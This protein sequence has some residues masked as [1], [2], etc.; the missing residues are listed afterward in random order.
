MTTRLAPASITLAL[1]LLLSSAGA[2]AEMPPPKQRLA[3]WV[4]EHQ[5]ELRRINRSI[6]NHAEV[7]LLEVESSRELQAFL[8]ANG[9]EVEAGVAGMPTA[10]VASYGSG[11][12]VI[13]VLAEYD[14]LP[15]LS[16]TEEPTRSPRPEASAG[17]GCGHSLFGT[18]SAAAAVA[19]RHLMERDGLE[20]TV[21]LYGTPAE[22]TLIGKVYM[23]NAGL[24]DDADA[25]L[26]W[27]PN[28]QTQASYGS[29]KALVS[30]KFR[31]RGLPTGAF[32]VATY[33]YGA[34]AHSWQVV[35][36][37]AHPI[38]E[39]GMLVAAKVMAMSALDLLASP[40]E[41]AAARED[42]AKRT[43]GTTFSSLVPEV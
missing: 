37:S 39:K 36:C 42:F 35:A 16:Q 24:F 30:A 7:G 27:H 29:S 1:A 31:F 15:G 40:E 33:T 4:D 12:P 13:A 21:R 2:S 14:A 28:D 20:G 6:W 26:S 18:A 5:E 3:D 41:L 34:P 11:R 25:V 17:H 9:F 23:V 10:F 43:E 22:E 8:G 32:A 38:G 19:L